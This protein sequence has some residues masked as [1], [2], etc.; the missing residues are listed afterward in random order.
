[1]QSGALPQW[2]DLRRVGAAGA[3]LEGEVELAALA[4]LGER[5]TAT[6]GLARAQV[7]VT[8]DQSRQA[9]VSG[10]VDALVRMRCE[11]CLGEVDVP[12]CGVFSL[13]V[14]ESEPAAD[15]LGG[16]DE[17]VVASGGRLAVHRL[18]EDELLLALPIV[19]R[20]EDQACDGGQRTFGPEGEA[21]PE[22]ENPFAALER[23]KRD[24]S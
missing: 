14:V 18:V 3:R 20:H 17:P 5:L 1:M 2:L 10:S 13:A 6:Q 7:V 21:L 8:F 4:R 24:R 23:L 16:E 12:L 22:R 9:V 15:A 19:A 11:R